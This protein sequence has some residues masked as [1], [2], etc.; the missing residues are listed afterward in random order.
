MRS[1]YN[2]RD[3][4]PGMFSSKSGIRPE[5]PG[6]SGLGGWLILIQI[7]LWISFAFLLS[8]ITSVTVIMNPE[9]WVGSRGVSPQFYAEVIRPLLWFGFISSVILFIL[10]VV[11]L[12]LLYRRKRWF[13]RMMIVQYIAN[14][15]IGV[16]T[17]ILIARN[18]I[19]RE[20]HILDAT[21]AFNLIIRSLLTCCIFIPYFLKSVRVKNTFIK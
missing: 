19:G 12:V 21:S 13:P 16:V 6:I 2:N 5:L 4:E 10:I 11:N 17:W 9:R 15:L 14:V 7:S 18:E 3:K 1:R 8:D 20:E